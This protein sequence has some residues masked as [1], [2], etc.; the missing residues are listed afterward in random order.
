MDFVEN[1]EKTFEN[2]EKI[3]AVLQRMA[4]RE[5]GEAG[6]CEDPYVASWRI[7]DDGRFSVEYVSEDDPSESGTTSFL[8]FLVEKEVLETA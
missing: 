7:L 6:I 2:Y 5:L 1:A 3:R 4:R 8:A